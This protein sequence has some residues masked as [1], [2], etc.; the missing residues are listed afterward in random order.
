MG[1]RFRKSINIGPLRI[2]FSKSGVGYSVGGKGFRWTKKAN[3]GTR[4][5]TTIPGTGI[6]YVRDYPAGARSAANASGQG[7]SAQPPKRKPPFYRRKWFIV[8]MAL[9]VIGLIVNIVDPPQEQTASDP[10]SEQDLSPTEQPQQSDVSYADVEEIFASSFPDG[11]ITVNQQGASI[12]VII[13]S[14]LPSDT[15]PENWESLEDAL[16]SAL[17]QADALAADHEAETVT[18]QL[19]AA[20]GTILASG[21]NGAVQFSLFNEAEPSDEE[22]LTPTSQ[23]PTDTEDPSASIEAPVE[24]P[25]SS[26]TEPAADPQPS[27]NPGN[28]RTVYVTETGSKYHY[29]NNCGNGTYYES[30]LQ[31]ALNRGLTPCKKCAGG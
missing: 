16:G 23:E 9:F 5:T 29:D 31:A 18:A 3:G 22:P 20:D 13:L 17:I 2:N 25:V 26:E 19:E 1:F 24:D 7:Q 28:E 21:Y 11:E 15:P 6:S 14:D 12:N 27:T 30:T 4:T 8:L 10:P